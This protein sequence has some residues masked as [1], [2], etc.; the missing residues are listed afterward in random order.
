MLGLVCPNGYGRCV[1][2]SVAFGGAGVIKWLWEE[3]W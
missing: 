2:V 1:G 3:C